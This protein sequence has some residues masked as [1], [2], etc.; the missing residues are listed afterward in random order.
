M[1][2]FNEAN[3]SDDATSAVVRTSRLLPHRPRGEEV[4]VDVD[5][6]VTEVVA[7]VYTESFCERSVL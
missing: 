2:V 7:V 1:Y 5:D 3:R 6:I 4:D